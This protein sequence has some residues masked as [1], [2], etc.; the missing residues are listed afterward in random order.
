MTSSCLSPWTILEYFLKHDIAFECKVILS[1]VEMVNVHSLSA[2]LPI[3]IWT[4]IL[5]TP[6]YLAYLKWRGESLKFALLFILLANT[7]TH[8]VVTFIIPRIFH[9]LGYSQWT[10]MVLK[11][12]FAPVVEGLILKRMTRLN[13]GEATGLALVTNLFS[14][15]M[16]TVLSD[17]AFFGVT[18]GG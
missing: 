17:S 13:W 1:S 12:S 8:P 3:F 5:E 15:W 10:G 7:A 6:F 4:V 18:Y 9:G 2:Y 11:E 14:W 16:G